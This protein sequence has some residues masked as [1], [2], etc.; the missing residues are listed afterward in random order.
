MRALAADLLT[1]AAGAKVFCVSI[2]WLE[3][4]CTRSLQLWVCGNTCRH[5]ASLHGTHLRRTSVV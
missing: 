1:A 5:A 4:C 2:C 3:G